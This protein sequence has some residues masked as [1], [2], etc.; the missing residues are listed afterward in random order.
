MT[1]S[2]SFLVLALCFGLAAV[3]ACSPC[4]RTGCDATSGPVADTGQAA[5]AG[6]VASES[7]AV[8][9][10]CQECPL[11]TATLAIW[12]TSGPVTD[13]AGAQAV[14]NASA[15]TVSVQAD[16]RYAQ[17]LDPGSYLVCQRPDCVSVD[18]VAAHVTTVHIKQILGPTQFIVFDAQSKSPRATTTLE[19]S[20]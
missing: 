11:G 16:Q 4:N 15:A 1:R 14:V 20:P 8:G 5:I 6:V 12:K 2:T 9:N 19:I 10:G 13:D 18:V 3:P 7:D 17:A